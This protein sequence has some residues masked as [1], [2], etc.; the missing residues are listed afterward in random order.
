MSSLGQELKSARDKASFSVEQIAQQTKISLRLLKALEDERFDQLSEPFFIKGVLKAYVRAIG[1]DEA[2]FLA[3]YQSE[4][5]PAEPAPHEAPPP[6]PAKDRAGRASASP[7]SRVHRPELMD[8]REAP[9]R[10]GPSL[11]RRIRLQPWVLILCLLLLAAAATLG[12]IFYVQ[13][14]PKP[15][16]RIASTVPSAPPIVKPAAPLEAAA[17]QGATSAPAGAAGL[18]QASAQ[19]SFEAGLKLGLR[20]TADTWIQVAADGR[21]VLDGIQAAGREESFQAAEEFILQLGNAGG[22]TYTLNGKPGVPF[23]PPGAVRTDVR[24]SRGTAADFLRK[25]PSPA[26]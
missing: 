3:L 21:I 7:P 18:S 10:S 11:K 17:K 22:V 1:A 5:A 12:V 15:A 24:I 23:G 6:P 26:P 9:G 14:R 20:F 8:F 4:H 2:Y 19:P 13:S 16:P 25:A